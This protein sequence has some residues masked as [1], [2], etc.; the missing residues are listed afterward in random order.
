MKLLDILNCEI[1]LLWDIIE[2]AESTDIAEVNARLSQGWH[3]LSSP[4]ERYPKYVLG[5]PSGVVKMPYPD[6]SGSETPFD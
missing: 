1:E 2:V 3:L 6:Y 5:R 4:C